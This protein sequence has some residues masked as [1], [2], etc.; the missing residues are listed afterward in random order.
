MLNKQIICDSCKKVVKGFEG[1]ERVY[2]DFLSIEGMVSN[3]KWNQEIDQHIYVHVCERDN[4]YAF[5]D[6]T[7]LK[8]FIEM[9]TNQQY[10]HLVEGITKTKESLINNKE[11][12]YDTEW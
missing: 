3:N 9:R 5:C 12:I 2:T 1:E 11:N 8:N 6:F 4:I 10:E 7:C